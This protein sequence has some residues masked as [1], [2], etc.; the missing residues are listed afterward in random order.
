[1]LGLAAKV[2]AGSPATHREISLAGAAY[3]ATPECG[4]RRCISRGLGLPVR[5][6]RE[7]DSTLGLIASRIVHLCS[8]DVD[9]FMALLRLEQASLAF[10]E[11]PLLD[12]VDWVVQPGERIAL[13]GRN[14]AGKSSLMRVI[15]GQITLDG[16]TLWRK[17]QLRVGVLDQEL[18]PADERR[19][20]EVVASG[21]AAIQQLLQR[22]NELAEHAHEPAQLSQLEALQHDIE[23]VD[24]WHLG[25]RVDRV[26]SRLGLDG[27]VRMNTLSGGWRRRVALAR[28]LVSEPDILLLDEPTNHL[29][30]ATIQ[31]L[32]QQLLEFAGT[33]LFVTHDRSFLQN[34]ANRIVELERGQLFSWNGDYRSFLEYRE[35][36]LADE[37]K[38]NA[39]FDKR[40]AQEE[41]W[42]RQG[43]KARRT[44]NEGRVRALK[45]M[46]EERS[47][48][49]EQQGKASFNLEQ[50]GTSGKL[51]S[52]AE[53]ASYSYDGRPLIRDFSSRIIRGDRIA[54]LGPNG[55][56]KSTLLKLLLGQLQP[57][58]GR[59]NLGTNLEI[60]YFDQLREQLDPQRTVID[61]VS[62]GREFIELNGRQRHVISYLSD[63]LFAPNRTRVKVSVLSG[64]ERNRL[65]LA[66]LFSKPANLLVLDEPTND[67]DLETL[68][69]LEEILC[70]FKGTLLLV[71]HDRAFVDN[72]VTSTYVFEGDGR[73]GEYVGGFD[74]WVRQGGGFAARMANPAKTA[75]LAAVTAAATSAAEPAP[76]KLVKLSYKLQRELD[77]LPGQIEKLEQQISALH[78]E[79]GAADF[80]Q[81]SHERVAERLA[82]L[83]ALESEQE[84]AMERWMEL[85]ALQQG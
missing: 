11:Q 12:H 35:R 42:I 69:L 73:I 25:Q 55:A 7:F 63:F 81:Q 59:V 79:T 54:L 17:D 68:E 70:E 58:S 82:L 41:V 83:Q 78:E 26:L 24:G 14:G 45:S 9:G 67:L 85:E 3:L 51:V 16:G 49:R 18:P 44:R 39:L 72:V 8:L 60:A 52:E 38:Q 77:Q 13:I 47:A 33:L 75:K 22:Y 5:S 34:L 20:D 4:W 71:S 31:W 48:R 15:S 65:M 74:D 36:R 57:D 40:L 21:Q 32:E 30:I 2:A 61:T 56:G 50:A 28:A 53:N 80:Y 29:D 37:E 10:G 62:E 84:R 1:L 43:I 23:A 66:R 46:R 64:G 76:Q 19:V 27:E 6:S